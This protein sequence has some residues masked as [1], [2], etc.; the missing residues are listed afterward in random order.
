ML[1]L[2]LLIFSLCAY[3]AFY[4]RA[5]WWKGFVYA[6]SFPSSFLPPLL[7]C[8]WRPAIEL[9]YWDRNTE[10]VGC[11]IKSPPPPN[12]RA[13]SL[14][15]L[16]KTAR[17]QNSDVSHFTQLSG[18]YVSSQADNRDHGKLKSQSGGELVQDRGA[19][20]KRGGAYGRKEDKMFLWMRP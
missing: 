3:C 7:P 1:L 17:F 12:K 4:G 13:R 8:S 19:F 10:D 2:Y 14:F 5:F 11:Q 16:L 6:F 18:Y 20:V 15:S 9:S